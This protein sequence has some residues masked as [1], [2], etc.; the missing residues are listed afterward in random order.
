MVTPDERLGPRK[1][2]S[3]GVQVIGQSVIVVPVEGFFFSHFDFRWV[4]QFVKPRREHPVLKMLPEQRKST[5]G[6]V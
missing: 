4:S 5:L 6:R 2:T 1:W 3:Q